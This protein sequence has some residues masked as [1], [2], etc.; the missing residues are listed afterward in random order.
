MAS[1]QEDLEAFVDFDTG[2]TQNT[3]NISFGWRP[4]LLDWRPGPLLLSAGT[5]GISLAALN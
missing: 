4:S 2:E 5:R 3:K 1:A